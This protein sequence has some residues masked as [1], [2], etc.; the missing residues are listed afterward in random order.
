MTS[1]NCKPLGSADDAHAPCPSGTTPATSSFTTT[2]YWN[3]T[4]RATSESVNP[5][6]WK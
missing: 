5:V 6:D 2:S 3:D 1:W 4:P